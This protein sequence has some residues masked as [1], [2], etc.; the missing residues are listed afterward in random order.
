MTSS[1]QSRKF[2]DDADPLN[3]FQQKKV[4]LMS[5]DEIIQL[6]CMYDQFYNIIMA[7]YPID[8][9][10]KDNIFC[11]M[12]RLLSFVYTLQ[13][14]EQLKIMNNEVSNKTTTS[15]NFKKMTLWKVIVL[16]I[17]VLTMTNRMM[18]EK[19]QLNQQINRMNKLVRLIEM[20]MNVKNDT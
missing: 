8:I 6:R 17:L 4:P 13:N 3:T 9:A 11:S 15:I 18:E 5:I 19:E 16:E 10:V 2:N 7:G 14:A 20:S 12:K 1:L